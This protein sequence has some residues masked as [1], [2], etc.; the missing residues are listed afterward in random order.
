MTPRVV[1]MPRVGIMKIYMCIK[2]IY[3]APFKAPIN[4][5]ICKDLSTEDDL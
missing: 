2:V 3:D 4:L 1:L 5:N